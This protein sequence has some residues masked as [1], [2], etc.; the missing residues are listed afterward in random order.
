MGASRKRKGFR[1]TLATGDVVR[2]P[3]GVGVPAGG[4][5][6]TFLFDSNATHEVTKLSFAV[7]GSTAKLT[8]SSVP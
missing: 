6:V 7:P 4:S 5:P 8:A 2:A 3:A 1:V